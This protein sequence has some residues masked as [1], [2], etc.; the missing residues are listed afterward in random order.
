[1]ELPTEIANLIRQY[2]REMQD[3][4]QWLRFLNLVFNNLLWPGFVI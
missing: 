1:M 3:H 4:E 2:I